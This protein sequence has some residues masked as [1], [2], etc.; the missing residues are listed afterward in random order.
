MNKL[1]RNAEYQFYHQHLYEK[2]LPF[3]LE[4]AFDREYG[5]CYTCFDNNGDRLLSTDKYLWS[6][7]RVV[8]F[9]SKLAEMNKTNPDYLRLAEEGY[10]F[11]SKHAFLPNGHCPFLVTREGVPKEPVPGKGLET[12]IYADC[13]VVLGLAKFAAVTGEKEAF[14]QAF[15]LYQSITGRVATG[16]F[17]TEPEPIP[18]G[19][20]SHGVQMILLNISQELLAAAERL[21]A[22]EAGYLE[23]QCCTLLADSL[24]TFHT[25]DGRVYELV[26]E[27]ASGDDPCIFG[28]FM[29]PGHS[30]E[31]MWF[32]IHFAR[33]A[34]REEAI[35]QA[36]KVTERMFDLGWDHEYG[37]L[38]HFVD[39]E[40]GK[41]RGEQGAYTGHPMLAKLEAS[42]DDK[43]W[44]V[45]SEALYTT[46]VAYHLSG[47]EELYRRYQQVKDYT[48]K[49]FPHPEGKEWIQ[50]RDRQGKPA[51]KV[52]AL[53]VKDPFHIIRN[54]LLLLELLAEEGAWKEG[55]DH[56]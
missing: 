14:R 13:F 36:V 45:H 12:S 44:W 17:R 7:G 56:D 21:Q 26:K 49:T 34:G 30:L 9:C 2:I 53:P 15:T 48:F 5:G 1:D 23:E 4:R 16:N 19:Y 6:Q 10:H 31:D 11:L 50:I 38:L 47:K 46:L 51:D 29:N 33:K 32:I 52:V 41:P 18:E 27:R 37:G 25:P 55:S 24:A 42:W 40:G 3:W 54:L 22:P 35:R 28:R 8:W 39:Q 43:L 20:R